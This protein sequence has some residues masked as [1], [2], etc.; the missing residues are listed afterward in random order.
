[1]TQFV[2]A[3]VPQGKMETIAA[4]AREKTSLAHGAG[5]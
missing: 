2:I 5:M 3:L 1:M 4:R